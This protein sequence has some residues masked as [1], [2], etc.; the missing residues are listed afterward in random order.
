MNRK[1][2]KA[3]KMFR[4][5]YGKAT[6]PYWRQQHAQPIDWAVMERVMKALY[7]RCA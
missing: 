2:R 3:A 1:R 7:A 4:R 6:H 5:K